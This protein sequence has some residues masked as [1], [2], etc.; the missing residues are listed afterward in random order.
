[1]ERE[2]RSCVVAPN[3]TRPGGMR[4][5]SSALSSARSLRLRRRMPQAL[6]SSLCSV[7]TRSRNSCYLRTRSSGRGLKR[8]SFIMKPLARSSSLS[9]V[10]RQLSGTS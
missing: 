8:I 6:N 4:P 2:A 7:K 10:S 5:A 9:P 1:M 3:V